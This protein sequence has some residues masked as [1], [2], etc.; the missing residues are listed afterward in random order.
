MKKQTF[1]FLCQDR[2][3]A[4]AKRVNIKAYSYQ[5]AIE[6]Y[7]QRPNVH[8]TYS[9]LI[10]GRIVTE[11]ELKFYNSINPITNYKFV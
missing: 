2:K 7:L 4:S 10:A 9:R 1:I 8:L 3:W 11:E 5:E 6:I